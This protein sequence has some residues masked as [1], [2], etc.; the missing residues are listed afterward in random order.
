MLVNRGRDKGVQLFLIVSILL[1]SAVPEL[2]AEE[3]FLNEQ[4]NSLEHWEPFYFSNIE[5]HSTY[6]STILDGTSCLIATSS[7]SAS[8][9]LLKDR[10]NVYDFPNI[11][12]RWKVSNVYQKGNTRKKEGDD[13]PVRL[14]VMFQYDPEKA[15]F[16]KKIKYE[17]VKFLYGEYPPHSSLNYIWANRKQSL[18]FIPNPYSNLAMMIPV[19]TGQGQV[20]E[21]VEHR[22]NIVQDYRAAFGE[23]PPPMT[24]IGVMSDSDNTGESARAYIDYI[25]IFRE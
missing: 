18:A 4:F 7:N 20:G 19:A 1:S 17:I 3:I 14:Y 10:F 21:W 13:Y 25:K 5:E 6:W 16:G 23:D 8:A 22:A 2:Q 9:I 11:V 24:A 12:W 15:S